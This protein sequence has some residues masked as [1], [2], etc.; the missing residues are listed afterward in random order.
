MTFNKYRL[1]LFHLAV[2]EGEFI[3]GYEVKNDRLFF[4]QDLHA[5]IIIPNQ[6]ED[7]RYDGFITAWNF[8]AKIPGNITLIVSY[9]EHT[10]LHPQ[11][12]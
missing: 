1:Y 3:V 10:I 4:H 2:P 11:P 6:L 5:H 9:G 7:V 8:Y 12:D